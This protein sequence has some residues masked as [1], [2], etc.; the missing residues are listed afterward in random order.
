MDRAR[1]EEDIRQAQQLRYRVF[2]DEMGASLTV[3]TG[4]PPGNDIDLVDPFC[5]HLLVRA[6]G[7]DGERGT[8]EEASRGTLG[9][10]IGCDA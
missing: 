5:E 8:A 1:D 2:S 10:S 9:E 7:A 3:P 4:S 6:H